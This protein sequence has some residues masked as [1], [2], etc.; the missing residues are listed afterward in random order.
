MDLEVT[1]THRWA[2]DV[3]GIPFVGNKYHRGVWVPTLIIAG[4]E[5][6]LRDHATRQQC[7]HLWAACSDVSVDR[8][9]ISQFSV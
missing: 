2:Q 5:I 3:F 7:L 4:R 8:E 6:V 9:R 1:A